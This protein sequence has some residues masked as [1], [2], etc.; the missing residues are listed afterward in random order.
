M[1][2]FHNILTRLG[3]ALMRGIKWSKGRDY[4]SSDVLDWRK[5]LG[6]I[7]CPGRLPVS[8]LR[9]ICKQQLPV[10][11]QTELSAP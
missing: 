2:P 5:R 3:G 6:A 7:S 10:N 9:N 11:N 8:F 1:M 4:R